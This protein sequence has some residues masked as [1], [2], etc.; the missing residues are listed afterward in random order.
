MPDL[1]LPA[2]LSQFRF[3]SVLLFGFVTAAVLLF[4]T[5]TGVWTSDLGADPDE[6]AHAV[7]SLMVRDYLAS[8][9]SQSPLTFAQQYYENFPK[10]A[11]GHYPPAYY[12]LA[13]GL[14]LPWRQPQVLLVLQ[15][16]L[17]GCLA[18]QVFWMG[19][20]MMRENTALVAAVLCAS[21]PVT[22][23]LSQLVM[24]DLLLACLSLLAVEIWARFMEKSGVKLAL[25]FGF[26][27]AAAILTK[28]S[29]LALALVPAVSLFSLGRWD[30]L[31]KPAFWLAGVPVAVLAG[32]WML[33][34]SK[35]TKEGMVSDG[36]VDF[37][38]GAINYYAF[39]LSST[40]GLMT[41][42]V[43]VPGLALWLGLMKIKVRLD[44]RRAALLGL[45]AGTALVMLFI[46]TGYSTRYF[47]PIVPAV[48]FLAVSFFEVSLKK[49][50][51]PQFGMACLV[52]L[53]WLQIPNFLVKN[54]TGYRTAVSASLEK[55]A[56]GQKEDW[57][58]CA[59][60]RGEG[61]VIAS[62]AFA[63]PA[64]AP[65]P[66]TVHRG[67]KELSTEDWLGRDYK[68][69]F[70]TSEA[71]TDYLDKSGI[72]RVFVELLQPE[73]KLPPHEKLL[74]QTLR[75]QSQWKEAQKLD[76]TR[77][78]QSEPATLQVYVRANERSR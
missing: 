44:P 65:S 48:A 34:S 6:P 57:L 4:Q 16:V 43:A 22:L 26:T 41:V 63:L 18:V 77:P 71:M 60:P 14:L 67:S 45:M 74:L 24:A 58:V 51:L 35:I 54:V 27:A 5:L 73:D 13:G 38:L 56:A 70:E 33:Y 20:K 50:Q 19:R 61:A 2:S 76:L 9:F 1:P 36:V 42:M 59:D 62:A 32:P 78:Y 49:T 47:M 69:A 28:G 12:A 40:F 10:V 53:L 23:K 31:K 66:L 37:A 52:L 30:L 7:T 39:S 3:R 15:A 72:R 55:L 64:Q 17:I 8:G 75:N 11:L 21:F 25:L 29:G 68:P 46:P